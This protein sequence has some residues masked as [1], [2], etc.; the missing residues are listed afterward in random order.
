MTLFGKSLQTIKNA[1]LSILE[2]ILVMYDQLNGTAFLYL[3]EKLIFIR[4][5]VIKIKHEMAF[6]GIKGN[7]IRDY[8]IYNIHSYL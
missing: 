8:I 5:D 6:Q 1:Y 3:C 4:G 7:E 2:M